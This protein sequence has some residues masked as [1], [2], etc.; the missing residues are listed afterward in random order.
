MTVTVVLNNAVKVYENTQ[1]TY[2][3][4]HHNGQVVKIYENDR[5]GVLKSKLVGLYNFRYVVGIFGDV[6]PPIDRSSD[7]FA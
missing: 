7:D 4:Y 3:S 6:I 5:D 1:K 2:F